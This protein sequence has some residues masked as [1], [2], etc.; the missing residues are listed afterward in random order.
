MPDTRLLYVHDPMCSWCYAFSASL[1]ALQQ[2]LPSDIQMIYLLGGLAADTTEPMPVNLQNTIQ[3]A[4]HRIENTVPSIL[5]NY[6]FWI[7]NTPLRSTYPACRALLASRKQGAEFEL[8]LLQAIQ[9]AYYQK[10]RNPSLQVTLQECA[11]E[12]GLDTVEFIKDLNSL[13]I[14]NEL[15]GEI[16]LARSMGVTSYPS[17]R[18][19]HHEEQ[20][21]VTIDYLNHRTMI[22]QIIGILLK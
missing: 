2:D 5:F 18:L 19:L 15:Q 9:N 1:A 6:D 12:T 14:D 21:A 3:Q 8:K 16:Q 20:I 22:D 17:L 10:A 4:W 7:F 13:A 11:A